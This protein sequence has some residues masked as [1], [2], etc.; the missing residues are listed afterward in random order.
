MSVSD[1]EL[2][3][4]SNGREETGDTLHVYIDGDGR[5]LVDAGSASNLDPTP[6]HPLA[7]A[8]A[9]RDPKRAVYLGR[10][11]H[12]NADQPACRP[13]L[14]TSARYGAD[15]IRYLCDAVFSLSQRGD[16]KISLIGFSG[17]GALAVHVAN[18]VQAVVN[19]VAVNG[20]LAIEVWANMRGYES[21]SASIDPARVGLPGRVAG[22]LYLVGTEDE[23]V[24]A[25][26][27]QHF[28]ALHGGEVIAFRGYGHRCCWEE[29]WVSITRELESRLPGW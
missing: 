24:P 21:L 17:G 9:A 29:R 8:L 13:E 3:W 12:F 27:S 18:C 6:E 16:R 19:V 28:S 1:L 15:V 20:N 14:W 7:L 11:C 4:W 10:P 2:M 25:A 26:V 5:P 22:R 23:V